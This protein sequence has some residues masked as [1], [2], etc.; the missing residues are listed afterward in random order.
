MHEAGHGIYEQNLDASHAGTPLGDACSV[1]IHESQ[2]RMWENQVGRGKPFWK[3][4]FSRAQQVFPEELGNVAFDDFL[5]A[6]NDV[7]PSLIRVEADEVTYNLHILLRFELEHAIINGDIDAKDLPGA[8]NEK[9][10]KY[11]DMTPPTDSDGC[12]QDIHWSSGAFGY[13]PTYTL[14]NLYSAQFFAKAKEEISGLENQFEI[15]QFAELK[16]W[17]TNKIHT[18][19]RRYRANKLCEVVTGK[20]LSAKPLMDY[21]NKKFGEL[22]DL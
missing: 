3:H 17:L 19:G 13:F 6:I 5:F 10:R 1:G 18:P 9:F 22:Y 14:G 2:S 21:L 16:N 11:F 20:P 4:F 8:W 12:M 15:G 7:R